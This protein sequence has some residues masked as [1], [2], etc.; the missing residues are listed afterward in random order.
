M[1]TRYRFGDN[2]YPHFITFAVIN[3]IDALSRPLYKDLASLSVSAPSCA[4]LRTSR[5]IQVI[6]YI[7]S[8]TKGVP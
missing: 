3:W 8:I 7:C 1:A 6:L 5:G 2:K 4:A